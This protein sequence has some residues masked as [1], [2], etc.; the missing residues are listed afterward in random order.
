AKV[1]SEARDMKEWGVEFPEPKLSIDKMRA[2]KEEI[3]G[4]LSKGL[5]ELAKRRNVKRIHARG[6]FVDSHTLQ[7][8]G[9]DTAT[10]DSQRLTYDHCILAAGSVPAMPKL[11]QIGSDRVMDSTSALALPDVPK[12]LLVIGGGY[13]GLEMGTVYAELGSDV[14][15]VEMTPGLLPGADRDLVK[16]LAKRLDR[17]FAEIRL[18]TKVTAL[19]DAGDHVEVD[20]ESES[21][22]ETINYDRVLVSVGRRPATS[23]IGLENTRVQLDKLGF[24]QVN[25]RQRT[26]DEAILAIGDA[27]GEPMLAH[28]AAAEGKVAAEVLAGEPA[29]FDA[30]AIPAVVFTDPEIAWAGI[31]AEQAKKEGRDV[32]IAQYPWQASGRAIANGRT[33][34][35]TKWL[36]DP[37]TDRVIGCG[38]VGAGAGELIAEAVVAIE[39]GCTVRDI[40]E[41]IHPHPTLSETMA[42]AGEV[43]LGTA[44]EVYRP[45]RKE[46]TGT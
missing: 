23:G 21:G 1:L 25:D 18:D 37:A 12:S 6:V 29:A 2:R 30:A 20:I 13:I 46:K 45:K 44:T 19:R 3:I 9:G 7:L 33:D 4:T 10:Y 42:F 17:L 24:V 31:T 11:F 32:K 28:K 35:M 43:Y 15:V 36:I 40:A 26:D 39:M 27:A 34:G 8:E 14:S 5:G 41:S 38:I 22:S 16:P